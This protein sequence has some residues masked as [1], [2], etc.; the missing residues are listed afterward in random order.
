MSRFLIFPLVLLVATGCSETLPTDIDAGEADLHRVRHSPRCHNVR[1]ES[2]SSGVVPTFLG[3]F[4]G[5]IDGTTQVDFDLTRFEVLDF[6]VRLRGTVTYNVTGGKIR[7]LIGKTFTTELNTITFNP[8]PEGGVQR[9]KGI[10]HGLEGVRKARL[11]SRGTFD[12]VDGTPPFE[13]DLHYRGV[14]CTN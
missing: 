12:G 7:S 14:I 9:V 10:E 8:P 6:G 5:D 3:T 11:H 1:Y 13:V 2:N 4:H